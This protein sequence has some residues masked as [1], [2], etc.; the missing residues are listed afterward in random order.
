MTKNDFDH[1]GYRLLGL[2][3]TGF[4]LV[5]EPYED[6]G[7]RLDI[8]SEEVIRRIHELKTL[9]IVR[10]IGPVIDARSLGYQSTLVAMKVPGE[11]INAAEQLLSGHPGISHGYERDHEFNIWITLSLPAGAGL[12][13]ELDRLSLQTG[14][15]RL[16][17]L[18]AT[19]VFKLRTNF[20]PDEDIQMETAIGGGGAL[21]KRVE[22]SEA[23]KRLVNELQQ[24]LPLTPDPF[25][26]LAEILDISVE[27]LLAQCISLKRRGVIRRYGASINHYR[28]GYKFNAMTCWKVPAGN[29]DALGIRLASLRQV[30][31]CY[32]RETNSY[33]PYNL[34]VM[35]H[36]KSKEACLEVVGKVSD[37]TGFTERALLFSMKEFKKTRIK[38]PV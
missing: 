21:T 8:N 35:V 26:H 4:P 9:G 5:R 24:D 36:G 34:F 14:A 31:H 29:V 12:N 27:D 23:D 38:Y 22:L 13:A 28:A 17:A 19:K 25:R 7:L 30:S 2:L 1:I 11:K 20:G 32:E 10:Q 15:E 16:F 37:E 3:Q 33:W 18:P 6:L